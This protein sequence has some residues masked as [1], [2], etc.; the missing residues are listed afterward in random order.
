MY[1]SSC[2]VLHKEKPDFKEE[3]LCCFELQGRAAGSEI[4]K[5][6]NKYFSEKEIV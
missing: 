4:F 1:H 5:L 3:L 6:R 2:F